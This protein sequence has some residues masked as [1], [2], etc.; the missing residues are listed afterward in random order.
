MP[1]LFYSGQ[2]NL[3][4][5]FYIVNGRSSQFLFHRRYSMIFTIHEF[6]N[7]YS[8]KISDLHSPYSIGIGDLNTLSSSNSI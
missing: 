6:D 8:T 2:H 7:T 4:L 5:Y 3:A 1:F